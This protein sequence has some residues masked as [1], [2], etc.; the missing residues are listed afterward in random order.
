MGRVIIENVRAHARRTRRCLLFVA[1][2]EDKSIFERCGITFNQEGV[3]AKGT[4][5]FVSWTPASEVIPL[6]DLPHWKQHDVD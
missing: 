5:L 1:R 3:K 2:E 6:R 4:T